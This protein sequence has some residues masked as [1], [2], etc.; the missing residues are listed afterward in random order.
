MFCIMR[1][2]RNYRPE[3]YVFTYTVGYPNSA[4]TFTIRQLTGGWEDDSAKFIDLV[5]IG[6]VG[7]TTTSCID[8]HIAKEPKDGLASNSEKF[9]IFPFMLSGSVVL[10]NNEPEAPTLAQT[11]KT[12][13]MGDS[14]MATASSNGS[15]V[16]YNL[17]SIT[18]SNFTAL[19]TKDYNTLYFIV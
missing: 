15:S 16:P 13:K 14:Y 3:L 2:F 19:S 18:N 8:I 4:S 17:V 1:S 9:Y 5:R 12:R 11:I 10:S 7:T 6:R